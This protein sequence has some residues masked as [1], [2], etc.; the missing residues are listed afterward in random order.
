MKNFKINWFKINSILF[1][2]IIFFGGVSFFLMPKELISENEK[3]QLSQLPTISLGNIFNGKFESEFDNYYNDNFIFRNHFI[4]IANYIKENFGI[5]DNEIR[6]YSKPS[7]IKKKNKKIGFVLKDSAHNYNSLKSIEINNETTSESDNDSDNDSLSNNYEN[8]KSVIVF[9]KRAIQIFGGSKKMMSKFASMIHKYKTEIN[10]IKNIYCMAIPVG[11]DFY[12]PPKFSKTNEQNS[13]RYLYQNMDTSI[14]CVNVYD[15]LASHK[16]EY[17]Q[18][19]T[20]HH[21]TGRG[22]YYGYQ[23]FCK[24]AGI[25]CLPIEKLQRKVIKKFLGTLYY[26]TLSESLKENIDSVEYFKIP[27]STKAYYFNEGISNAKQ[28]KLYAE[29]ARGGNSYGVFLGADFPL[30]KIVSDVKNGRKILQIKDSYGNAFAP[31]LPAHFE[32]VYIIDYRYFDGNVKELIKKYGIT[33]IIFSH[34]IYVIN[35]SFTTFRET[36]MLNSYNQK[37]TSNKTESSIR[38]NNNKSFQ[39]A[40]STNQKK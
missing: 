8:I 33:D 6:F 1:F 23:A 32:E 15:E 14:R 21:W 11:S 30:M 29:Y 7:I 40:D 13:I 19:N 5:K 25:E 34:N 38:S 26:Y 17:I 22:A 2:I 37:I 35:S 3:R 39:K 24:T 28:T 9:K 16:S 10:G 27:N 4:S 36:K 31:F 18:F 12:L 20:D